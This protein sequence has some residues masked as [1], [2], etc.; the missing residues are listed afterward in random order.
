MRRRTIDGWGLPTHGLLLLTLSGCAVG[1]TFKPPAPP[2]SD[3]YGDEVQSGPAEND[4]AAG[5]GKPRFHFGED[6]AGEWWTLFGSPE[7]DALIREA[8][9]NYPDIAAQQAALRAARENV[10]AQ[11]GGY[12]PQIQGMGSATRE[13]ISGASL[14]SP[15][16]GFI[17]NIFQANVNVSYTFDVFG[18]RGGRSRA[19]RRRRPRKISNSRRATSR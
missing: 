8:M 18:N 14:G 6:L 16:S 3:A 10:R 1:P 13:K 12:F 15:S 9:L 4:A 7:L 19:Y 11:Q 17:T 2:A 5:G